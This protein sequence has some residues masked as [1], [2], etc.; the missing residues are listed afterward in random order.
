MNIVRI[1]L[2]GMSH[3]LCLCLYEYLCDTEV[4]VLEGGREGGREPAG[5]GKKK[6][7]RESLFS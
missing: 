7:F 2:L 3:C 1:K 6:S 5:D 4:S